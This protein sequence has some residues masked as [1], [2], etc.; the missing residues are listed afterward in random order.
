MPFRFCGRRCFRANSCLQG[1]VS[2]P[3]RPFAAVV[4]GSKVSSKIGVIDSLLNKVTCAR[5]AESRPPSP[6]FF[7]TICFLFAAS[8]AELAS[9]TNF[10]T[11]TLNDTHS[12][13]FRVFFFFLWGAAPLPP[14]P[15][16]SLDHHT[17][18]PG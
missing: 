4:G 2:D 13:V 16:P 12:C 3:K 15:L 1:A 8:K 5:A 6:V 10:A 14:P 17:S 11:S 7:G 9:Y 18:A